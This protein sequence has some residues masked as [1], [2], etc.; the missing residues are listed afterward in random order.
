MGW[1]TIARGA[2]AVMVILAGAF[3]ARICLAPLDVS[4]TTQIPTHVTTAKGN[5][6]FAYSAHAGLGTALEAF[7]C[8]PTAT[9]L[10]WLKAAA[11]ARSE[12]EAS[13][14]ASGLAVARERSGAGEQWQSALCGFLGDGSVSPGQAL[15]LDEAGLR[16]PGL[17]AA[18]P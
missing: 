13:R 16:C 7:R 17:T 9:G 12:R 3:L 11:H 4:G 15:A 5:D 14:A 2:L 6:G 1:A 8:S 10:Q 18:P